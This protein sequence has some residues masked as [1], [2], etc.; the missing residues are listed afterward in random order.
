MSA[1]SPP[2]LRERLARVELLLLDVDGILTDG[3]IVLDDHGVETKAFDVTDGHGIKLLQRAGVDV[4]FI[5]GRRSLVVEHRARELGVREVHQG[6]KEK[7]LVLKEILHRRE[8]EPERVAYAGDDVVDLPILLRVG[9]SVSVPEAPEYV[10]ERV[11]WV[12]RRSGGRGA[13]R[14][15]CDEILKARDAWDAVTRRYFFP[16]PL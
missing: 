6:V 3:R 2:S 15:I 16:D 10:R 7:V 9:L 13:V 1:S 14:E 4:G 5:T 11:H 12:T 8:L